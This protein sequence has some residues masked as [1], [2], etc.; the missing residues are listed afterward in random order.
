MLDLLSMMG[1]VP[2]GADGR[3]AAPVRY[4]LPAKGGTRMKKTL[5]SLFCGLALCLGLLPVTALAA[6]EDAPNTLYVG[7]E[8]LSLGKDSYWTTNQDPGALTPCTGS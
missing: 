7:N 4:S 8:R 5:V 1:A 2:L 6:G 3:A